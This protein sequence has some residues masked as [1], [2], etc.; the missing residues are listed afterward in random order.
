[1]LSLAKAGK[2]YY[3]QKLG[4]V[5]PREDYYLRG[6]TAAGH[7]HGGGATDLGLEGTVTA[8]GLVRLFDG[9]DPTTGEQLG[10]QVRKD[11]VAAWDLTF[12]ADK[13]VSLLWVF[14]DTET[15]RHVLEAFQEATIEAVGYLEA[16][17]SSTRGASR[18]PVFDDDG[19][20]V[21]NPDGTSK[22]RV[23]T[24][25]IETSGYVS[26][27]FTEFTSRAD[28]PQLHTHVVVGNRVQGVDGRWR[29]IDGRLLYR[30]K[31][32]AGYI[33]EAELRHRLTERLGV[34]WQPVVNGIADI[35]GFTREQIVA[36]SKRRQQINQWRTE[37]GIAD[38]P[39]GNEAATLATRTQKH[40]T[41][42]DTLIEEWLERGAQVG[43]TPDAIAQIL[44]RSRHVTIPDPDPLAA[45]L[46]SEHG[47]T[48]RAATFDRADVIK[49]TAAAHPEG[50]NRRDI[51]A[52]ADQFLHRTEV[53]PLLPTLPDDGTALSRDEVVDDG[54]G[55]EAAADLVDELARTPV[56]R[57]SSGDV[58]PGSAT[59]RRY[60]TAELLATE[61]RVITRAQTGLNAKRWTAD[62]TGLEAR[63]AAHPGLTD[64]QLA[65]VHQ[66]ATSG[67]A[68][69]VRDRHRN[70]DHRDGAGCSGCG[71]FPDC[72]R[73][74][75][76]D[77]D[78][79]VVGN[80]NPRRTPIGGGGRC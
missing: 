68:I 16:E 67:N 31:L 30:H 73:Y 11:G 45:I 20:P 77:V 74:R 4:R 49:A 40:D 2:D 14:G 63:L 37:H 34:R 58:F 25:P 9:Q 79:V 17:A 36:F 61:Q 39:A 72:H 42:I 29:T 23:E 21:L 8:E 52:L 24:W 3:L 33:H 22:M 57:C 71:W 13:S 47:L 44:D 75:L 41:P 51:E 70:T 35:D 28:D 18:V 54:V 69:D 59:D 80:P 6:G 27:W 1:M 5:S 7:W 38:T 46:G 53:V 43:L 76:V 64:G 32:A 78:A 55:V 10:R 48:E 12:S 50:G 65:M 19:N 66:F 60:T 62:P 56:M 26:A 15:R